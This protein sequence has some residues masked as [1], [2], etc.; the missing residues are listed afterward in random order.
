MT[1]KTKRLI[2][3]LIVIVALALSYNEFS[4]LLPLI[5]G[6]LIEANLWIMLAVLGMQVISYCASAGTSH[7]LLAL[8]GKRVR[9][10]DNVRISI[11]S[12][13]GANVLPVAGGPIASYVGFRNLGVDKD[14]ARYAVALETTFLIVNYVTWFLISLALPPYPRLVTALPTVATKL[15]V[16]VL[17]LSIVA[18]FA[19]KHIT[20]FISDA[21]H[22]IKSIAHRPFAT[23]AIFAFTSAY[24]FIDIAMLLVTFY[25]FDYK[26]QLGLTVFCYLSSAFFILLT[27]TSTVPGVME[28]SLSL[29]FIS[30][31][32]PAHIAISATVLYR[33]LTFWL[34]IPLSILYSARNIKQMTA[35][36]PDIQVSL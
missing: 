20:R 12:E 2:G 32:V 9:F 17:L 19:R 30:F 13:F 27:A 21:L 15:V 31:G 5:P 14:T 1:N 7:F 36:T 18:Y 28:G 26:V 25:A 23:L 8:K 29:V 33:L 11:G 3:T 6:I 34:W 24:F 4:E 16:G 35:E 10:L 22:N